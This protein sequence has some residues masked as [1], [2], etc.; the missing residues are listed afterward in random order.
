MV[1][2]RAA[3]QA[4]R[5]LGCTC[6]K[7]LACLSGSLSLKMNTLLP[8]CMQPKATCSETR[9]LGQAYP[10]CFLCIL[11]CSVRGCC[12]C[13]K[14]VQTLTS[15]RNFSRDSLYAADPVSVL[16]EESID[17]KSQ[18]NSMSQWGKSDYGQG[19]SQQQGSYSADGQQ[20]VCV[21]VLR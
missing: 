17:G 14:L 6:L 3:S 11:R 2:S 10:H 7:A 4:C 15:S 18:I 1:P 13:K 16:P 12:F 19:V 20:Q 9:L 5:N 21:Q 8:D